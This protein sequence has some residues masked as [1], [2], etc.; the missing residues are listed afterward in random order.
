MSYKS[1][2]SNLFCRFSAGP[3]SLSTLEQS[4]IDIDAAL[5]NS[6][7]TLVEFYANWCEVCRE[8]AP[9]VYKVGFVSATQGPFPVLSTLQPGALGTKSAPLGLRRSKKNTRT[10]STL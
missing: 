2:L 9:N 8:L 7:P 4:A 6:N 10:K 5:Q 1:T 3:V